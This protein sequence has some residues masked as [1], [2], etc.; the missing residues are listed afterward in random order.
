MT[1]VH[2]LV[3]IEV[4]RIG[5]VFP[6]WP[7][8]FSAISGSFLTFRVPLAPRISSPIRLW[9]LR[10]DWSKS[11]TFESARCRTRAFF[12]RW[13]GH[14]KD[15]KRSG[16]NDRSDICGLESLPAG[17]GQIKKMF[18]SFVYTKRDEKRTRFSRGSSRKV[19]PRISAELGT[20]FSRG[21]VS[22][23]ANSKGRPF[24]VLFSTFCHGRAS[25]N[26]A[27]VNIWC[28]IS[29]SA[30]CV[31]ACQIRLAFISWGGRRESFSKSASKR[32][33]RRWGLFAGKRVAQKL[34]WKILLLRAELELY[35]FS[36]FGFTA[37]FSRDSNRPISCS[38]AFS[39]EMWTFFFPYISGFSGLVNMAEAQTLISVL[40]TIP[41]PFV[42][43]R[44]CR[45]RWPFKG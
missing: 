11:G 42:P 29:V 31:A 30:K 34:I 22:K 24:L 7:L 18:L 43:L 40:L 4:T 23:N 20:N 5:E 6:N 36:G 12:L 16:S 19:R 37:D 45:I 21:L 17:A 28:T 8:S 1:F 32:R 27:L 9:P 3:E 15:T 10:T 13:R 39:I 33:A 25:K 35:F 26:P 2:R 14:A 44:Y 41:F 38:G